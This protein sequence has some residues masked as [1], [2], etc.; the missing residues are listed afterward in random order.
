MMTKYTKQLTWERATA[1][2]EAL[3]DF[4]QLISGNSAY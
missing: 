2:D 1:A 3:K 4:K